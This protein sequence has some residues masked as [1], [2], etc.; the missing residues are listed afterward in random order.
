MTNLS[1]STASSSFFCFA[2]LPLAKSRVLR[3]QSRP[4]PKGAT[5]GPT[6]SSGSGDAD[7]EGKRGGERSGTEGA[8]ADA[9]GGGKVGGGEQPA[10]VDLGGKIVPSVHS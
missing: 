7:A 5:T 6:A 4:P 3:I 2:L 8:A 1:L 9:A 10:V